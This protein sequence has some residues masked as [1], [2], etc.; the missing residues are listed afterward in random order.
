MSSY[1][2]LIAWKK[3]MDLVEHIYMATGGFPKSET[4]G[5]RS[6]M[7]RSAVSIP[8]NI[9]EGQGRGSDLDFIRFLTIS[10]GSVLELETQT[11]I[12]RRLGLLSDATAK[13]L[14]GEVCEVGRIVNGLISGIE[15]K[16]AHR[17]TRNRL[18]TDN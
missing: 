8:C 12:A 11:E 13:Q 6:Q 10:R 1:R 4:Y 3:S 16:P 9:A 5:L 18:T 14:F 7:R 15:R 17:G 2:D